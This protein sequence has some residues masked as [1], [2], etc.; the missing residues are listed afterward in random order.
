MFRPK[1]VDQAHQPELDAMC[2]R[3]FGCKGPKCCL[4]NGY[5]ILDPATDKSITMG[6]IHTTDAQAYLYCIGTDEKYRHKGF[7]TRMV[8]FLCTLHALRTPLLPLFLESQDDR[9]DLF[10]EKLGWKRIGRTYRNKNKYVYLTRTGMIQNKTPSRPVSKRLQIGGSKVISVEEFLHKSINEDHVI[11]FSS[12]C[13][14]CNLQEDTLQKKHLWFNHF[15]KIEDNRYMYK[16]RHSVIPDGFLM[17]YKIGASFTLVESVK[18][19]TYKTLI[20]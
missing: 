11:S 16:L 9:S 4:G 10:Y 17:L 3:F 7:A 5:M 12:I 14:D 19:K 8:N 15:T 2:K 18:G 6:F 20:S 1:K 13:D